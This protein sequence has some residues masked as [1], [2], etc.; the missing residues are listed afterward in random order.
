MPRP[1]I[2]T[3]LLSM[4]AFYALFT[5]NAAAAE[6]WKKLFKQDM[7]TFYIDTQSMKPEANKT[8]FWLQVLVDNP[9]ELSLKPI[10]EVRMKQLMDCE[11]RVLSEPVSWENR[12][13]NGKVTETGQR[14]ADAIEWVPLDELEGATELEGMLCKK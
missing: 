14:P 12:D 1:S 7:A 3:M 13:E 9:D 4:C 8:S 5:S 11:K 2:A 10:E 6:E